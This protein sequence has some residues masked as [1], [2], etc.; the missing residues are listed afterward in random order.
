MG[1]K[2]KATAASGSTFAS[3]YKNLLINPADIASARGVYTTGSPRIDK[4]LGGGLPKGKLSEFYGKPGSG[5][6]TLAMAAAGK[7]MDEGGRVLYVDL[8]GGLDVKPKG[9]S[10]WLTTNGIDVYSDL[11]DLV[12]GGDGTAITGEEVYNMIIESVKNK[13]HQFIIIDSMAAL[14]TASELAGEIG[15]SH[16]G[17]VAKLNSQALR[18]LMQLQNANRECHV[19]FI[20]Q[21]RDQIAGGMGGL[22]STGGRAV[23]HY[24]GLK[25]RF[26]KGLRVHTTDGDVLTP[27]RVRVEKSR[28]GPAK[29]AS[30]TISSRRGIDVLTEVYEAA[31][32][33]GYVHKDGS[34]YTLYN[35]AVTN[36][37]HGSADKPQSIKGFVVR[38]QGDSKLKDALAAE[39]KLYDTLY[40]VAI[41]T[42]E[43]AV[44]ED[45]E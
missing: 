37:E 42:A 39:A 11:F 44:V 18:V 19:V 41:G 23:E 45:G 30:I 2:K 43:V 40:E 33:A 38:T 6:S 4:L 35:R 9:E 21:V 12:Q 29:E 36:E 22:K 17:A 34:W 15:D 13:E 7:V 10:S 24:M 5:K 27:I 14:T 32:D 8:E 16:F 28:F 26:D 20:N 1:V 3:K 31:L 25:V